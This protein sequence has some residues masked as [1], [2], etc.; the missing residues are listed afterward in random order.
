MLFENV[1]ISIPCEIQGGDAK[2]HCQWQDRGLTGNW[3]LQTVVT[4]N[5]H[6]ILSTYKTSVKNSNM[7]KLQ[8][9]LRNRLED[10]IKINNV[11]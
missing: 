2:E 11:V 6:E 5:T 3:R 10:N 1:N 4:C 8:G 9:R 7:N